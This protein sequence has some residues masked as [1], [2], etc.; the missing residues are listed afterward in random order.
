MNKR[1]KQISKNQIALPSVYKALG[2]IPNTGWFHTA[3]KH[4]KRCSMS[5]SVN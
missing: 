4:V 1:T 3:H 2:S 5:Y